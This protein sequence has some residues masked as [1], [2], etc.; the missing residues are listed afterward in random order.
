M[1]YDEKLKSGDYVLGINIKD[2]VK[3]EE[4]QT[5]RA[6]FVGKWKKQPDTNLDM[7]KEFVGDVKKVNNRKLRIV[8]NYLTGSA[9]RI[10]KIQS[11]SI[12]NY[13]EIIR[14]EVQFR[15]ENNIWK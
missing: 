15:K 4:W 7:L 12:S 5:L 9:F 13:T 14:N 1:T 2:I 10:G 6:Y 3:L 11:D 8:Q